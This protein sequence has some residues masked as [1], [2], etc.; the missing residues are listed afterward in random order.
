M[1]FIKAKRLEKIKKMLCSCDECSDEN[2]YYKNLHELGKNLKFQGNFIK[3]FEFFNALG[4]EERLKI[5]EILKIKDRCVCE[6]EAALDK[7]QSS[8]S[9][10]LRILEGASLIRGWKK[11]KFTY[12]GIINEQFNKILE[13]LESEFKID[14]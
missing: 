4:N 1:V 10:H 5:I 11:G 13:L 2:V 6:L 3:K 7:S 14:S 8:I 12:Y 9:H